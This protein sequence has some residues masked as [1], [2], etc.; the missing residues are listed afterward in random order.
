MYEYFIPDKVRNLKI[1]M[2]KMLKAEKKKN[3]I[4][5]KDNDERDVIFDFPICS[6]A[7]QPSH[8]RCQNGSAKHKEAES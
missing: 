7:L 4:T 1:R 5:E 8:G 2:K 3:Q 6:Q